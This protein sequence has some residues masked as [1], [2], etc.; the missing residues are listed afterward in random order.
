MT[1]MDTFKPFTLELAD[2]A[3]AAIRTHDP[4][5]V[6]VN[7]KGESGR[8][9][10]VT[11]ADRASETAIRALIRE[12]YP[13]HG[14]IGEEFGRDRAGARHV[15]V[16]DPI[17]GT[18]AFITGTP[19]WGILVA[20][21]EDG[22]PVLGLNAQPLLGERYIGDGRLTVRIDRS[23]E[24]EIRT[25]SCASLSQA[26]VLVSSACVRDPAM[27]ARTQALGGQVRMLDY[28][29]NCY[30]MALLSQGLVDV[31]IGF[32]G[33]EIY[34]IAAHMPIVEG[35]GGVISALDGGDALGADAIVA[36]GDAKLHAYVT[37]IL[38]R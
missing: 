8:F 29:A 28:S 6:T 7:D 21:L 27:L 23:G 3:E 22:R 30:T 13:D 9:D 15:W 10:P 14:V 31:V 4:R 25:R 26:R 2:A 18:R 32:G 1:A 11:A 16:I 24:R 34:D 33:F 36:C 19:T 17:D 20:L 35:A 37:S 5:H 38:G 12:R